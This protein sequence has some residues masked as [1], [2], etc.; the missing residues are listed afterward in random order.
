MPSGHYVS[1]VELILAWQNGL[2]S[3]NS[4]NQFVWDCVGCVM[5]ILGVLMKFLDNARLLDLASGNDG[6]TL[7]LRGGS[8][9]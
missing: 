9:D 1:C 5:K 8:K 3:G 4:G 7:K 2:R 6:M